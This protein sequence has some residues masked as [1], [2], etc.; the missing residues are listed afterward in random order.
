MLRTI[1]S[2]LH[3]NFSVA[4]ALHVLGLTVDYDKGLELLAALPFFREGVH[5]QV[6]QHLRLRALDRK[7]V[8]KVVE[9]VRAVAAQES[10]GSARVV[11]LLPDWSVILLAVRLRPG[12]LYVVVATCDQT[13]RYPQKL[14]PGMGEAI[15]GAQQAFRTAPDPEHIRITAMGSEADTV[16]RCRVPEERCDHIRQHFGVQDVGRV[17]LD[18]LLPLVTPS[19]RKKPPAF[20]G[21]CRRLEDD[22]YEVWF[23]WRPTEDPEFLLEVLQIDVAASQAA[24][25]VSPEVLEILRR[26][27]SEFSRKWS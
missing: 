26:H 3:V 11:P 17:I 19:T 15:D 22:M 25:Q 5:V 14:R 1:L 8:A 6:S 10:V 24:E 21:G 9:V 18:Q 16:A 13:G 4:Y 23:A 7:M 20:V 27:V 12:R 2:K